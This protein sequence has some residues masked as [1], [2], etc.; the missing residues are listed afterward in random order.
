MFNY[1][2]SQPAVITVYDP[3]AIACMPD[4]NPG[5]GYLYVWPTAIGNIDLGNI[6]GLETLVGTGLLPGP[7]GPVPWGGTLPLQ[8]QFHPDLR[9]N[10]IFYYRWS[11]KFDGQPDFTQIFAT[12]THRW[13]EVTNV[14]GHIVIHLHGYTFGPHLVNGQSNLFE[15]P[16]PSVDW[17]D[18]ND[19]VDRPLAYFDSTDGQTP[20]RT[21]MC[22]LKLEMFDQTGNH[23]KASNVDP[24]GHFK[25]LLPELGAPAGTYTDAPAAN[26]DGAGDLIFKIYVD[27]NPTF[28][29]LY[30][31]QTLSSGGGDSCG[32]R[33]FS[34]PNDPVTITYAATQP[35]NYIDWYLSVTKGTA[36]TVIAINDHTSSANPASLTRNASVFLGSCPAAAFAVNLN[37]YARA[38]NGYSTQTQYDRSAT[39]AFAL[40]P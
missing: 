10:N 8:M 19:P 14:A 30:D 7:N 33:H 24:A 1:D 3:A 28:A 27:N 39:M 12:V 35:E 13:Q 11:Y 5:P 22:T 37:C 23:V 15:I 38:T 20:G 21:G 2:G 18:I 9:A 26:V 4:P 32:I 6:D 36:G 29:A 34:G 16:D 25:F 17:I 40:L 31:A